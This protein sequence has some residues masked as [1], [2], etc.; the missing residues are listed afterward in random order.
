MCSNSH[1]T[2]H[3]LPEG[4]LSDQGGPVDDNCTVMPLE[5][6]ERSLIVRAIRA[7]DGNQARAAAML[8]IERRRLYRKVRYY[9]LQDLTR[10]RS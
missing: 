6:A 7:A 3:D 10:S 5:V 1:I 9:G 2:V 4:I 8:Q